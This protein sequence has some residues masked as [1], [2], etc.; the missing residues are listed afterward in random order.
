MV[1][2]RGESVN[3]M[4]PLVLSGVFPNQDGH[5]LCRALPML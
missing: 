1:T 2:G 3:V 4:R 5:R